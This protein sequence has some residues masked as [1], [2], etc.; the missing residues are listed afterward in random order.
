MNAAVWVV[1][2]PRAE[3]E[4]LAQ[5]LAIPPAL[6][7]VLVNRKI[8]T[9]EAA[10]AFL[11]GDLDRL[12]DPYLMKGMDKAVRR[13]EEAIARGEKILIFGDYDVD[14]V[15]STVMLKKALTTLGA[16]VDCFIPERLTDAEK[17]YF[18]K[19]RHGSR[20]PVADQP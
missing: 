13:I 4:A 19:H 17:S 14:G 2:P 16:K 9:E 5:A 12:H 18:S 7:R 3:A 10:R 6:A 1:H 15:L 11:Y 20:D 8:L